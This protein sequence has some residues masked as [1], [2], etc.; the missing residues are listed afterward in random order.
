MELSNE[1]NIN[2]Y[3][4]LLKGLDLTKRLS[5]IEMLTKSVKSDLEERK[6]LSRT[7]GSW[8]SEESAEELVAQIR[9]ERNTNRQIEEL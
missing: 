3:F 2:Y 5:L 7:F 8:K 9:S 1:H 4:E 6:P